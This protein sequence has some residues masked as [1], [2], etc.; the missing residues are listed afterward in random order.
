VIGI[1]DSDFVIN[2]GIR[3]QINTIPKNFII[4]IA[5]D[6]GRRVVSNFLLH[7]LSIKND[8]KDE[9]KLDDISF[10]LYAAGNFVKQVSYRGAALENA[11]KDFAEKRAWLCDGIGENENHISINM[12]FYRRSAE[13]MSC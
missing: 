4:N 9:V 8:S 6:N 5:I 12:D 11:V 10:E 13:I 3:V 2:G 1:K 7:G